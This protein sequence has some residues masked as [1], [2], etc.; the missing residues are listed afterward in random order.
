M[1]FVRR[2]T[3]LL[4]FLS[5]SCSYLGAAG[6]A[7]DLFAESDFKGWEFITPD[8]S[9]LA[10]V[11]ERNADRVIAVKGKPNGYIQ[12]VGSFANYRLHAEWRW[13]DKPGNGG[14][15]VHIASGA[16]DRNLWPR[17]F[18]IQLKHSSVGNLLPMADATFAE[19]LPAPEPGAPLQLVHSAASSEKPVGEWNSCDIVC[20]GGNIDVTI[21]GVVQN[22][23]THSRPGSG[24]I[25][26]QLEGVP[27]ELRN[28]Q[29][30]LLD[31]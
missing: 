13:I 15:L 22:R 12:T 23:V 31:P 29:I 27:F 19:P 25:G 5:A 14:V 6:N 4:S 24:R 3:V 2:A 10:T 7:S 8:H 20:R 28:V 16:I 26:F 17:C 21:N 9:A 11:C 1:S 18:Q 30:E